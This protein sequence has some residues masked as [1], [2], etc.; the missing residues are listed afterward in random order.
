MEGKG[1]LPSGKDGNVLFIMDDLV[2]QEVAAGSLTG[3]NFKDLQ[4]TR[5]DP[6]LVKNT[7]FAPIMTHKQDAGFGVVVAL[8]LFKQKDPAVT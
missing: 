2:L 6:D 8:G 4:G 3:E 5:F 1:L 7:G